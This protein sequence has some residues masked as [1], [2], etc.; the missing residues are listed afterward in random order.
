MTLF[1]QPIRFTDNVQDVTALLV[2]LGLSVN[3]TSDKGGW[4]E[5]SGRAGTV[6]L[7]S[8]ADSATG[9]QP[10]QTSLSFVETRTRCAGTATRRSRLRQR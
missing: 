7:H 9:A 3:V 10:G 1:V 4:V 6:A 5:L 8:A 2:A